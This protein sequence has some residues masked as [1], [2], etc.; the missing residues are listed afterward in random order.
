M[1]MKHRASQDRLGYCSDSPN[2]GVPTGEVQ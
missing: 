1:G 2:P